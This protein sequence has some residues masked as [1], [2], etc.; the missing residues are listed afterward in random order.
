MTKFLGIMSAKGG[1]G[2]T[3]TALN[4]ATAMAGFNSRVVLID[5]NLSTP[6]IGVHLG[7][8]KDVKSI[9][10]VF[11][12]EESL[13]DVIYQ[14]SSGLGIILG[15]ISLKF[16]S[17]QF[18]KTVRSLNG[19]FDYVIVDSPAGM[20]NDT[21]NVI[22]CIDKAL[23]VVNP[24]ILSCTEGLRLIRLIESKNKTVLGVILNK[25][26]EDKFEIKHDSTKPNI[27]MIITGGTIA[28]RYDSK[29]GGVY[30]LDTPESLFKFYPEIFIFLFAAFTRFLHL[31]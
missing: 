7:L 17:N 13:M 18:V 6:H 5:G 16:N 4:I 11:N 23:I 31:D 26:S 15:D 28:S 29:T 8:V 21:L 10:S 20:N 19:L 14:H 30:P 25:V 3:T 2:K 24:D 12:N 22:E 1:V 27:G 9:N